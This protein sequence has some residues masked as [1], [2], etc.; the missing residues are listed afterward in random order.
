MTG[1]EH[2]KKAEN[3]FSAATRDPRDHSLTQIGQKVYTPPGVDERNQMIVLAQV[4]ATL[5][6]AAA[7]ALGHS[8]QR[9]RA[10]RLQVRLTS[11]RSTR[12][13]AANGS[14]RIGQSDPLTPDSDRLTS[15]GVSRVTHIDLPAAS[16]HRGGHIGSSSGGRA[17]D[18]CAAS[19]DGAV[20][21]R[22]CH[23][24]SIMTIRPSSL[25]CAR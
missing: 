3:L 5:A 6:L 16:S 4:H 15:Q 10:A 12:T 20:S 18:A 19:W 25:A 22:G 8:K 11:P 9:M 21:G 24:G 7:T 1:P 13:A 2:S 14:N 23:Q 17:Q